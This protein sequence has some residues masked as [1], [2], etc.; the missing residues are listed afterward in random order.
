MSLGKSANQH[1]L[2][3][4]RDERREEAIQALRDQG[5][6]QAAIA[7]EFGISASRVGQILARLKRERERT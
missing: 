5:W 6:T 3:L 1:W 4:E 2:D 7:A